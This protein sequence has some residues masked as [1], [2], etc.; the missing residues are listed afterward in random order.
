LTKPAPAQPAFQQP[1]APANGPDTKL[2]ADADPD[3][4]SAAGQPD[5]DDTDPD[6]TDDGDDDSDATDPDGADDLGDKGKKA[7]DAMKTRMKGYRAR[8]LAAE[9]KLKDRGKT[10]AKA[11][12]KPAP[13][14]TGA[15]GD[16][17]GDNDSTGGSPPV[18]VE[19]LREEIAAELAEQQARD[20]VRDRIE[21]KAAKGFADPADTLVILLRDHKVDD[22]LDG[23]GKPDE[24]AITEAL[25]ELLEK[26]PHL[27]AAAQGGKRRFQGTAEG[28]AK[29]TKPSRPK[30]LEEAVKASLT[31]R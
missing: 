25:D 16:N 11:P 6:D 26:K 15:T 31:A 22:F 27:G 28:G 29:P 2:A 21:V 17:A 14:A 8:A 7:L 4:K 10:P 12:A 13:K 20:R 18:D 3:D 24:E 19:K 9:Q 1:P 23:D 5:G 30:S